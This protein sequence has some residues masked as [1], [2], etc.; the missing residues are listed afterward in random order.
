MIWIR[1]LYSPQFYLQASI[2]HYL[3]PSDRKISSHNPFLEPSSKPAQVDMKG[4]FLSPF[5]PLPLQSLLFSKQI[6]F[7]FELA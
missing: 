2:P 5:Y 1:R 3:N 4:T 6:Q 7:R